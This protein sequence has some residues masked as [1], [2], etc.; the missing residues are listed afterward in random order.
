MCGIVAVISQPR[1]RTPPSPAWILQSLDAAVG[2]LDSE[3]DMPSLL[4]AA[5]ALEE[6]NAALRTAAGVRVLVASTRLRDAV[7]ARAATIEARLSVVERR[8][9][10]GETIARCLEEANAAV[11]RVKDAAW[12]LGHDRLGTAEA[13]SLLAG[14]GAASAV[15][16][17]LAIQIA[18][19][20]LDRLEVRGRD[21][22]GLWVLV[23]DPSLD[24]DD[25]DT[26]ELF[27][28][29]SANTLFTCGAVRTHA[30]TVGFVYKVASETGRL[31]DNGVAL[32]MAIANDQLLRQALTSPGAHVS[33]LGH[34]RWAS[35]GLV[36]EANAH[37]LSGDGAIATL[38]PP[39]AA[40]VNGDIDNHRPLITR[41]RLPIPECVTTDAKVFPL[42]MAQRLEHGE[43]PG[44]AFRSAAQSC[45]GS[46]AVVASCAGAPDELH[47]AVRG[48][49]QTLSIGL[50]DDAF[51]VASEP[52][53]VVAHTNH[54]VRID[55]SRGGEIV[56]LE[57]S[58]AGTVAAIRRTAYGSADLPTDATDV[59]VAEVTTRD[60]DRAGYPHYLIKEISE[61]AESWRKTV[62][63][64]IRE[65]GGMLTVALG[66]SI[67]LRTR[68]AL[69]DHTIERVVVIG[70]GTAAVAARAVATA[71]RRALGPEFGIDAMPATELSGFGLQADM[72][73]TIVIAV[74]Q[75]GTTT[76]TNRTVDVV[77]AR[78]AHV[79]AI[80]NRRDSDLAD[81][82]D[83]VVYTSDG[84]DVEMSVA[85]TKAF[86]A[87]VA[88]GFLL[89]ASLS[90]AARV[91]D[92]DTTHDL[93][94]ALQAFP[95]TMRQV[96][97]ARDE[98]AVAA[99]L[100]PRSC[101]WA[102]VGSGDNHVAAS[103]VRI[104]LSE[105][106]YRAV[107]VD[108]TE[109][110]KHIDLSSEPLVLVC[111]AGLDGAAADDVAKEVAIQRAHRAVPIVI[112]TAG[113]ERYD[114]AAQVITVPPV[115]PALAFV[116][117]AMAGHLFAYESALA[118][119]RL[120]DPL[121]KI[122]HLSPAGAS[123]AAPHVLDAIASGQYDGCLRPAT[124]ARLAALLGSAAGQTDVLHEAIDELSRPIDAIKHQAK[125]VTVGV[126]RTEEGSVPEAVTAVTAPVQTSSA[127][128]PL[129]RHCD[130]T[131]GGRRG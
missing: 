18:L 68:A 69:R 28:R 98:I 118:I 127:A 59:R 116:L 63:G 123:D 49:G 1:H 84:R 13:V 32:R 4:R 81:K 121:R 43:S 106:C 73:G 58:G 2:A 39:V 79:I 101:H 93:A 70:Q 25:R 75:S 11:V 77:K 117:S 34:T 110:K 85:S 36:T 71:C 103:E 22:A 99:A 16:G 17:Y 65:R 89:A 107:A 26:A 41:H 42:L 115:Y 15:D 126:S 12:A 78:G 122:A 80:V 62:R 60:I 104:K 52:Y 111:A 6:A 31:G 53:G 86:Y 35:A 83:G 95:S 128:Q 87:Q 92:R 119:D 19:D 37:P 91:A 125:T 3:R 56:V 82:A 102:V 96:L 9:D 109:D 124:A 30:N 20:A 5:T 44:D 23:T 48:S 64:R 67:P 24:F 61:A 97:A 108:V 131:G 29:R 94:V 10:R 112:A 38:A 72:T 100:A 105:L 113:D 54:Y 90:D 8:L 74:S 88:A 14:P 66:E 76:D 40:A 51:V 47:L 33:V 130:G 27:A 7:A 50:A 45:E 114:V 55:G 129:P 57:R 21:S 120:A 46:L